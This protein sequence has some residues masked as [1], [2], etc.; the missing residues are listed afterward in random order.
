[1]YFSPEREF[2]E[3]S[4]LFSQK[5]VN[6]EVRLRCYKGAA[7]VLGRS[8]ETERLYSAEE[9]SMDSL[10]NFSPID[11]TGFIGIQSIRLKKYGLQ[12]AE[13]GESLSRV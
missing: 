5:R 7:Y 10:D 6:G 9:A 8:S 13:E 11:T 4:L 2:V 3:N 12:K 1:M